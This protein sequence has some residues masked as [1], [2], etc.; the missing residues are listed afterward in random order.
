MFEQR[1]DRFDDQS[2]HGDRIDRWSLPHHG[3]AAKQNS[4]LRLRC[5]DESYS[6]LRE[7]S[8]GAGRCTCLRLVSILCRS[9][10]RPRS[11]GVRRL[12]QLPRCFSLRSRSVRLRVRSNFGLR[13]RL[14]VGPRHLPVCLRHGIVELRHHTRRRSE[15]LRLCLP[16]RLR[17]VQRERRVPAEP[18]FVRR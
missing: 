16:S 12:Q 9:D 5:S 1:R 17:R 7:L 4:R 15:Y 6:A 13:Q 18:V 2:C 10:R 3:R 11:A 14:S 8:S